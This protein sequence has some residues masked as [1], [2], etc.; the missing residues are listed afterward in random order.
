[1]I[2]SRSL[3]IFFFSMLA[4]HSI[5]GMHIEERVTSSRQ[6]LKEFHRNIERPSII[7]RLHTWWNKKEPFVV[8]DENYLIPSFSEKNRIALCG[9]V[10]IEKSDAPSTSAAR[11]GTII[12]GE[13]PKAAAALLTH[14]FQIIHPGNLE[15]LSLN[16]LIIS[17]T[18]CRNLF[19]F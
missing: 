1:M 18:I 11:G 3:L 19:H 6:M 4:L 14:F 13:S 5:N 2:Q 9:A 17:R 16:E 15:K 10:Q 8:D 12:I 7:T